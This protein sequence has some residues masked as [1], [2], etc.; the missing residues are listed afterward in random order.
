MIGSTVIAPAAP[1][2]A[3]LAT[4]ATDPATDRLDLTAAAPAPALTAA[5]AFAPAPALTPAPS[6]S[7]TAVPETPWTLTD[8]FVGLGL[9]LLLTTVLGAVVRASD[10]SG[11]PATLL[12]SALP[13]WVGLLGTTF[14]ACRRHGVGRLVADLALRV[15]WSDVLTGVLV[16]IGLRLVLGLWAS[17]VTRLTREAA[18]QNLPVPDG[19]GSSP[20]W[21]VLNAVA[22]AI[23]APVVEEI[24]F[25]GLVLRSALA[26]LL[27]RADRRRFAT[28]QRRATYAALIS[29]LLFSVLHLSE[30]SSV[31]SILV[32]LPGLFFAGW[33]MAKLTLYTHRL[34]P[35]IVTHVVFN[36][37]AVALLIALGGAG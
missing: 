15:R 17:Q 32:L 19:L 6:P 20:A 1:V 16:G 7:S 10:Y 28:P 34:G 23:V 14:W 4:S 13:I 27:R 21:V 2:A 25:R 11:G 37:T 24:F 33:V 26:T 22:I 8:A 35:A 12:L 30:V 9:I 18:Q 29:A 3:E 31:T 36:G 5:T